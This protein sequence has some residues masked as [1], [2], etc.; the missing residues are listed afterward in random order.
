LM[1][2]KKMERRNFFKTGAKTALLG[3][4]GL[5]LATVPK[6]FSGSVPP[7]KF[8]APDILKSYTAADHR[9]R[10]ESIAFGERKIL[11][12]VRKHL[13]TSYMPGHALISP[14]NPDWIPTDKDD[15]VF[16]ALRETGIGIIQPWSGWATCWGKN[17]LVAKNPD[18]F[19]RF[20]KLAQSHGLKVIPYTSSQ[21]FE[22]T[23]E[24]FK[25]EWA[26]PKSFDLVE[27]DYHLAHCS[28]ASP[29]WRAYTMHRHL[30]VL[31]EYGVDGLYNDLG[32]VRPGGQE[33]FYRPVNNRKYAEDDVVAFEEGPKK[34]GAMSDFLALMYAEVKRRGGIYKLH[35]EGVDTVYTDMKIYD[36]LWVGEATN[37][38]DFVRQSTKNY[39][40]YVTPQR[41]I[42]ITEE[43]ENESFL[44]S[45]PFMQFPIIG[46][47]QAGEQGKRFID[48]Y[49]YWFDL[50]RPM[51]EE[52]TWVWIDIVSSDLFQSSV[53][54]N[55]VAS[56]F[57]NREVF[58][59]IAN[60]NQNGINISTT[61]KYVSVIDPK[62]QSQ[63]NWNIKSRSMEI[64][65][66]TARVD[67]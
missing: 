56:L 3:M 65:K 48:T 57:I 60:Y 44:N 58:L 15:K 32:Y 23:D 42:N 67:A 29:E 27:H 19:K 49:K 16:A 59:V 46:H 45:V 63:V 25:K 40:P 18:G 1:K 37:N 5:N 39:D 28:P 26:W 22:R 17:Y 66:L 8:D 43:N 13:V 7:P 10:L 33:D 12:S 20:V 61:D 54:K 51:T 24:N 4:A 47:G 62:A 11:S 41:L 50:Y 2:N 52:G 64:L 34:D 6:S 14:A 31:D 9:K 38:I 35:K 21:F 55:C 53:P 36:Y 30:R